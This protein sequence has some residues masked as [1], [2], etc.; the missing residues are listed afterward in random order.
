[1]KKKVSIRRPKA[2]IQG[3]FFLEQAA[4]GHSDAFCTMPVGRLPDA[5][6]L[7]GHFDGESSSVRRPEKKLKVGGETPSGGKESYKTNEKW[8][9]RNGMLKMRILGQPRIEGSGSPCA[10]SPSGMQVARRD[11]T[12]K[13]RILGSPKIDDGDSS[14]NAVSPSVMQAARHPQTF[15]SFCL[16][17]KTIMIEEDGVDAVEQPRGLSLCP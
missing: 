17:G 3:F 4:G 8:M 15:R 2:F 12:L 9:A 1:M 16:F 10:V 6:Q 14:S 7:S 11:R 13:M 5:A